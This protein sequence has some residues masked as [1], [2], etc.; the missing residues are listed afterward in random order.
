MG[1]VSVAGF[2]P[3]FGRGG[4]THSLLS[5]DVVMPELPA[6]GEAA[7]IEDGF[8]VSDGL[9]CVASSL[10]IIGGDAAFNGGGFV[11]SVVDIVDW[12]REP[13]SSLEER[14]DR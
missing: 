5:S 13:C 2:R 9:R 6:G 12:S 3:G 14:S 4:M 1:G 10:L 11:F 8:R 7:P